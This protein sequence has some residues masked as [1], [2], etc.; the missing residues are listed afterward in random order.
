MNR[1]RTMFV[2]SVKE[3]CFL[4]SKFLQ[5]KGSK[6]EL[7]F[8]TEPTEG[9]HSLETCENCRLY[10]DNLIDEINET[11][12]KFPKC[13]DF[14]AKLES[15]Y[16]F[17]KDDF[18]DMAT[19]IANKVL[20]S[21]HH[22]INNLDSDNWY[23]D[24]IDYIIY[25]FE[26]FGSFP[27]GY[28]EPFYWNNYTISLL[29]LLSGI[30]EHISSDTISIVDL[31][32][33]MYKVKKLF[34]EDP[35]DVE[36]EDDNRDFNLLM[37]TYEQW[38]KIFPFELPYFSHLKDKFKKTIPIYTGRTRY[39]K[40]LNATKAEKHTKDSL[41][42]VLL[43]ITKNI[44]SS[45]NG[46]SLYEK[47]LISDVQKHQIDLIVS[48]RK[49]QLCKLSAM[50]NANKQDYVKVLKKWFKEEK[51]FI[52]EISPLLKNSSIASGKLRP[53]RTDIAYYI[54]YMSETKSLKLENPFP[55]DKAWKEI[56]DMFQKNWK[57]IQQAY[58][59]I[60][61][62]REERLKPSKIKNI[63]FVIKELLPSQDKALKLAKD[64]LNMAKLNS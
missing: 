56:G 28:G 21:Y 4:D 18:C 60:S 11:L 40:Y 25:N 19:I 26:S 52:K 43:Q 50:P 9:N 63:E 22:I 62:N 27:K 36:S 3:Y 46:V 57:N 51:E 12:R 48:N 29:E 23:D 14:H 8:A 34:E 1:N 7:P 13:C 16:I 58:N 49:L 61:L 6:Y 15:L 45:I 37:S 17:N 44:L 31:K 59:T 5:Y 55:S 54:Q 35:N 2:E 20:Y 10:R 42:V 64:E 41:T 53:N 39:N 24:I 47:Q 38:F 33:R 32:T 30:E